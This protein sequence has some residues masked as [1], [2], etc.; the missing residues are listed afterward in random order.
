MLSLSMFPGMSNAQVSYPYLIQAN[1]SIVQTIQCPAPFDIIVTKV[2]QRMNQMHQQAVVGL[3]PAGQVAL[4]VNLRA[5][6]LQ[7]QQNIAAGWPPYTQR[8]QIQLFAMDVIL[9]TIDNWLQNI[10]VVGPVSTIVIV[11]NPP[12]N[13][14]PSVVPT[15]PTVPNPV[16]PVVGPIWSSWTMTSNDITLAVRNQAITQQ[17]VWLVNIGQELGFTIKNQAMT[18]ADVKVFVTD[19]DFNQLTQQVTCTSDIDNTEQY[20]I[21]YQWA[22][23]VDA[24]DAEN[25]MFEKNMNNIAPVYIGCLWLVENGNPPVS[26]PFVAQ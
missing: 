4:L 7:R 15:P 13:P 25:D 11:P 19:G 2:Q 6:V 17:W 18:D 20:F 10:P 8:E 26:S 5:R 22:Y 1:C 14:N 12:V 24:N 23:S 9:W 3:S 21:D 16:T